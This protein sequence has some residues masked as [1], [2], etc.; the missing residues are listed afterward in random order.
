MRPNLKNIG[1]WLYF[2]PRLPPFCSKRFNSVS[3]FDRRC[4]VFSWC[5]SLPGKVGKVRDGVDENEPPS[6]YQ[7]FGS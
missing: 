4:G 2:Q 3:G 6:E 1:Y 5:Y 7:I